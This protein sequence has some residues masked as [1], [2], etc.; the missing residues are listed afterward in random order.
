MARAR[1]RGLTLLEVMLAL[2]LLSLT[3]GAALG[4][5]TLSSDSAALTSRG[6]QHV[7]DELALR[8][9]LLRP[10]SDA[11]FVPSTSYPALPTTL[12]TGWPT[13]STQNPHIVVGAG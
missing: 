13:G 11:P 10:L 3:L 5:L 8:D 4:M 2:T 7:Q 6:A 9:Q 1:T 12:P